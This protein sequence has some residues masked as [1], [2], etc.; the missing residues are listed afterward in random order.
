MVFSLDNV[1]SYTQVKQQLQLIVDLKKPTASKQENRRGSGGTGG[2]GNGC[3]SSVPI[4]VVGN[5]LDLLME[6][7]VSSRCAELGDIQQMV[8]S[9]AGPRTAVYSEISARNS[10]GI[11]TAFERLFALAALPLEML[12][13]RHRTV[14]M[15]T[16]VT[17]AA[18]GP[19]CAAAA[20]GGATSVVK[21]ESVNNIEAAE[22]SSN[23]LGGALNSKRLSTRL[24]NA[25]SS[26][27]KVYNRLLR[28]LLLF[29][30]YFYL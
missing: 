30:C 29:D 1:D 24:S 25:R 10:M 18:I 22:T 27:L 3:T 11:E 28:V 15:S 20:A 26:S 14:E 19:A 4:L 23:S 6:N 9:V 8:A 17:T 13:N 5:K 7:K 21:T 12:P 16:P 2:S